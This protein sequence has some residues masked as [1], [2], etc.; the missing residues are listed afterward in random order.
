M[1]EIPHHPLITVT[2]EDM[3][4]VRQQYDINDVRRIN[5]AID[6]VEEWIKKQD[7]LVEA[8]KYLSKSS[9]FS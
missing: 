6:Q 7:H 3:K 8:S 9:F 5:D 1:E 2:Q 4:K